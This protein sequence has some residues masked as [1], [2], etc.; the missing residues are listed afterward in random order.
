[1]FFCEISEILK[2]IYYEKHLRTAVSGN[3]E[4]IIILLKNELKCKLKECL[5]MPHIWQNS[6][7]EKCPYSELFWS[8]FFR[9]RTE[10][11]EIICISLYLVRM[12]GNADQNNSKYEHFL[13]SDSCTFQ[14]KMLKFKDSFTSITSWRNQV[15]ILNFGKGIDTSEVWAILV[16]VLGH[17][18]A[19]P[20]L[21]KVLVKCNV[22]SKLVNVR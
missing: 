7:R 22:R 15:I 17:A 3:S 4:N 13:R 11:E 1:M 6:L 14:P 10:Y 18:Q 9:I 16:S 21:F 8:A 2:N 19:H 20:S 5:I 12:R